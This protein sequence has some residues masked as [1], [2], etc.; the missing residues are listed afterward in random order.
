MH[1]DNAFLFVYF[2]YTFNNYFCVWGGDFSDVCAVFLSPGRP[3]AIGYS[4][5]FSSVFAN[6][7]ALPPLLPT[8]RKVAQNFV[9]ISCEKR[10]NKL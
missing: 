7:N 6:C 2:D 4:I 8:K 1:F 3:F 10:R 9:W 5:C